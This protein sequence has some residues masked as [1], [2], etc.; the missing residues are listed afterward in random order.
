LRQCHHLQVAVLFRAERPDW[1]QLL[2]EAIGTP[3]FTSN[4]RDPRQYVIGSDGFSSVDF[5]VRSDSGFLDQIRFDPAV[6]HQNFTIKEIEA[7][8]RPF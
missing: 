2:F 6:T 1:A 3:Y 4:N 7:R 8:C 5:D